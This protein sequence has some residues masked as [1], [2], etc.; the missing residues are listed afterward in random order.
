MTQV[1]DGKGGGSLWEIHKHRGQVDAQ[2]QSELEHHSR[3]GQSY[4]W[5]NVGYDMTAA[6]TILALRNTSPTRN[7]HITKVTMQ[8][9]I[10]GFAQHHVT[11][12]SAALAG[13]VVTG[14]NL[15]RQSGNV[16]EADARED[17]TTNSSQGTLILT[18]PLVALVGAHFDWEGALI[19]G[20]N[21]SYAI[22]Y[23]ADDT[24]NLPLITIEGYF[25]LKEDEI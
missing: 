12:G 8:A 11:D 13:T 18:T 25:E 6:D 19:L 22:D 23:T 24:T 1:S 16:A 21:D 14:Y 5:S 15:N 3:L 20:T 10:L 9:G 4:I 7:L 17:E 2:I